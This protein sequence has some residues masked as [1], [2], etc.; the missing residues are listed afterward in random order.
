MTSLTSNFNLTENITTIIRP[1]YF[2]ISGFTGIPHIKYYYVFLSLV[3]IISLMGN[4]FVMFVIYLHHNLHRPKYIAVFNLAFTDVCETTALVPKLL[5]MFLFGRQ[6]ISYGQCLTNLFFVFVFLFMQSFNLIVLAYDRLVA[7]CLPLRYHTLVSNRSMF[8]LIGAAWVFAVFILLIPVGFITRLSFC[9]SVV[10]NSYFCDHG[11]LYR[12]AAPCSD[13][14]PN[15]VMSYLDPC[16]VFYIPTVL[17]IASYICIIHA[18][19]TITLPQ[20]RHRAIKTCT[21]HLILVTIF[22]LPINITYL[23]FSYIPTNVRIINLSLTSVLTPMLN[24]II[25]V[26]KTEEFKESAKKLI[27]SVAQRAILATSHLCSGALSCLR[28]GAFFLCLSA[29]SCSGGGTSTCPHVPSCSEGQILHW[30]QRPFLLLGQSL[31]LTQRRFKFRGQSCHLVPTFPPSS[32]PV[33]RSRA[34][35]LGGYCQV[36]AWVPLGI[37]MPPGATAKA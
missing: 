6:F 1:P 29:P 34:R 15:L 14:L 8:Q 2:Y 37:S 4:T 13:I 7:I 16:L 20:D 35:A 24:P 28:G 10:I 3:Y 21:S 22:Y 19:F 17:I 32:V 23:L 5:D 9:G 27:R 31:L 11:P 26:L 30:S 25:Y 36:L 18:L 33:L 12:L